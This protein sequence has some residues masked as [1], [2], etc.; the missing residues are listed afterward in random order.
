M[1]IS[2]EVVSV[3]VLLIS[4][5][6]RFNLIVFYLKEVLHFKHNIKCLLFTTNNWV[7]YDVII[8]TDAFFCKQHF[9]AVTVC[10]FRE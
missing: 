1:K 5:G 9:V 7:I 10:D 4:Y 3:S 8:V 2:F 6:E